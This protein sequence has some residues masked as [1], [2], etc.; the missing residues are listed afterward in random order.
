MVSLDLPENLL[1]AGK[2]NAKK[3]LMGENNDEGGL[4]LVLLAGNYKM[5]CISIA[6]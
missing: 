5:S 3:V 1:K 4:F 2:Y 6:N